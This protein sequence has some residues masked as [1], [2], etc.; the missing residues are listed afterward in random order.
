MLYKIVPF[1]AW[2][3]LQAQLQARA[4]SIPTMKEMISASAMRGQFR[5]HV[6]AGLLLMGA[7]AWPSLSWPAGVALAGSALWLAANLAS[8][9]RRFRAF[10][11]HWT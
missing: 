10:G 8:A 3:H 2:F 6:A 4:G 5:L 11:G 1:L 7:L 9:V